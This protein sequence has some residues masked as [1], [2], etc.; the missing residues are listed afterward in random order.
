MAEPPP[1]PEPDDLA[2][3]TAPPAAPFS[4]E[5]ARAIPRQSL[6]LADGRTLGYVVDGAPTKPAVV[7][8]HGMV[9]SGRSNA[10]STPP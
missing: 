10:T 7:L 6:T 1:L 3:I 2:T 4:V 8:L 9:T 5:R